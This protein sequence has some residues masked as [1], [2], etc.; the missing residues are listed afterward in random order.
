MKV[1]V[2]INRGLHEADRKTAIARVWGFLRDNGRTLGRFQPLVCTIILGAAL[3]SVCGCHRGARSRAKEIIRE[4]ERSCDHWLHSGAKRAWSEEEEW[5]DEL[6]GLGREAIEPVVSYYRKHRHGR[7]SRIFVAFSVVRSLARM[8]DPEAFPDLLR[9]AKDPL[10]QISQSAI[11]SLRRMC[12]KD[13]LHE[14][15]EL[16]SSLPCGAET[17]QVMLVELLGKF[18]GSRVEHYLRRYLHDESPGLRRGALRA[19]AR[20]KAGSFLPAV[21]GLMKTDP[22]TNVRAAAAEAAATLGDHRG[23]EYLIGL[24]DENCSFT[25]ILAGTCALVRLKEPAVIPILSRLLG[26]Q[27]SFLREFAY[28][29]LK[30]MATPDA[31]RVLEQAGPLYDMPVDVKRIDD[32]GLYRWN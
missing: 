18:G 9:L 17:C 19:I 14:I 24:C 27:M 2:G 32:T 29:G 7:G 11:V 21:Q 8:N 4:M 6:A 10:P 13:H 3:A 25:A 28:E 16:I 22:N 31:L 20:L 30:L 23:I 12:T 26:H 1:F 15:I 5:I